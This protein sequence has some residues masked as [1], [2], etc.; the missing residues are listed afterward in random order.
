[1]TKVT[2][3]YHVSNTYKFIYLMRDPQ[4]EARRRE[5]IKANYH[6]MTLH[7]LAHRLDISPNAVKKI[8]GRL[9]ITQ[10]QVPLRYATVEKDYLEAAKMKRTLKQ[11]RTALLQQEKKRNLE[12]NYK[13]ALTTIAAL[14][15]EVAAIKKLKKSSAVHEI[16]P[17]A[18]KG[19]DEATVVACL[20]D[21]H[22]G[23]TVLPGQVQGL[24]EYNIA[25]AKSRVDQFFRKVARLADKERQ[26]V[27]IN[28]LVLFLGGDI[29]DGAL[30]LDTIMSNEISEPMK[31]AVI[32]Q[33][34]IES[35][36]KFLEGKFKRITI[37]CKDGNHGR[38]TNKIH[39]SSRTGNSL[40][41]Y[42][43][44]NLAARL[45]HFNWLIE[46]GL[47]TYLTLY[48][49]HP[50][51]RT[52]R[53]HHGDTISFGGV[54]GFYTYLNR[55]RYQWNIAKPADIDV[56]GHLHC[57][58]AT[59][60]FVVNGSVVGYNPFAISLGAEYEPAMQALFL[61]D[62]LRGMTVSMPIL[63]R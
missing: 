41:W 32:A 21:V 60:R 17:S 40:E 31:Q 24:N 2:A 3:C 27:V 45:P 59:K 8:A 57:Y 1:M 51:Q 5:Y 54:N 61:V 15:A 56:L 63:F 38:V 23:A 29:I 12:A 46:E 39:H 18:N 43:Y 62:R 9:G 50:G 58:T 13:E 20:T 19:Q 34:L 25:V 52:L 48:A 36:L 35:G 49:G 16:K 22:I 30:H 4:I 42:M 28:E 37:V 10:K 44:Y 53:F 26:D 47:H 33:D 11:D 6:K 55:R 7:D 14:E